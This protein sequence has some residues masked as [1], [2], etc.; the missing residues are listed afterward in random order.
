[1]PHEPD[2]VADL[3][4]SIEAFEDADARLAN[5]L[6]RL[7]QGQEGRAA[8]FERVAVA[9]KNQELRNA[10]QK[11]IKAREAARDSSVV[12][13][14]RPDAELLEML[15]EQQDESLLAVA[16]LYWEARNA[17]GGVN[18][19]SVTERTTPLRTERRAGGFPRNLKTLVRD[20]QNGRGYCI[21]ELGEL[22]RHNWEQEEAWDELDCY[23]VLDWLGLPPVEEWIGPTL[24]ERARAVRGVALATQLPDPIV[25]RIEAMKRAYVLV[26]H[27]RAVTR[28]A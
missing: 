4:A 9:H 21:G 24:A 18:E 14:T 6:D 12:A 1:M 3:R 7:R 17:Q 28:A 27:D 20:I 5:A 8:A 19:W 10:I 25:D 16:K 13:S 23:R 2:A 11:L 22:T 26:T 15:P